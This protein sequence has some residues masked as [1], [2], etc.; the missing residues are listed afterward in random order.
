MKQEERLFSLF[1]AEFEESAPNLNQADCFKKNHSI[2][3]ENN[4]IIGYF[5]FSLTTCKV[6]FL[7]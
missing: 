3:D 1:Q 7:F 2:Y 6:S 4:I 5:F